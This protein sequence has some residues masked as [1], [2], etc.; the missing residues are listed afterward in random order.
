MLS[1]NSRWFAV[2]TI[3]FLTLTILG[4][5]QPAEA[6]A[7]QVDFQAADNS[8]LTCHEDLY[9][10]HDTGCWYCMTESHRD[11][12]VDCH[13]GNSASFKEEAAHVGLSK[14]PQENDGAKCLECHSPEEKEAMMATF[15]SAH[16]GFDT[17]IKAE[18]YVP[19]QPVK[20][21]F[22]A[23]AEENPITHNL[24]WLAF[25]FVMFG[26]WLALVLRS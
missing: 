5:T 11:R 14:H 18:A 15:E 19:S 2:V 9:Y 12:C 26:L 3:A 1:K 13:E 10:L 23:M 21:G 17:V 4:L 20:T 7:A 6:R 16:G 25:G 8:C 22:P 24:G